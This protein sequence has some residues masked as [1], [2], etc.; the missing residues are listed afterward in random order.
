MDHDP[1]KRK[2]PL[3]DAKPFST[4][5]PPHPFKSKP[6]S[7]TQLDMPRNQYNTVP[8]AFPTR[9]LPTPTT[10][11]TPFMTYLSALSGQFSQLYQFTNNPSSPSQFMSS[12]WVQHAE[13]MGL[14]KRDQI[15]DKVTANQELF[16]KLELVVKDALRDMVEIARLDASMKVPEGEKVRGIEL[17]RREKGIKDVERLCK[18]AIWRAH[19]NSKD[20]DTGNK[21]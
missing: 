16:K 20:Q 14:A 6:F 17:V 19:E 3:Q 2:Q 7:E 10:P 18:E 12:T 21:I 1:S 8:Y 9:S 11:R 5:E 4:Y 13:G 15:R